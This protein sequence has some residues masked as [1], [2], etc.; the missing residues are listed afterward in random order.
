M[1][2]S[3]TEGEDQDGSSWSTPSSPPIG[4]LEPQPQRDVKAPSEPLSHDHQPNLSH[5]ETPHKQLSTHTKPEVPQH[6]QPSLSIPLDP[7]NPPSTDTFPQKEPEISP[8]LTHTPIPS[9]SSSALV[10]DKS[11]H[12]A[13][14]NFIHHLIKPLALHYPHQTLL[15]LREILTR[16]L[17]ERYSPTWDEAHPDFGSGFRSLICDGEHG[18]PPQLR[19]AA[20]ECGVEEKVWKKALALR[21]KKGK[22]EEEL[23]KEDWEAWCDPGY[24]VWRY[25]GWEWEDSGYEPFRV[26]KEP[27]HVIWQAMPA[28]ASVSVTPSQAPIVQTSRP[29]YAIPIRAPETQTPTPVNAE[30]SG[31][32]SRPSSSEGT[33]SPSPSPRGDVYTSTSNSEIDTTTGQ[34]ERTGRSPR[35]FGGRGSTSS[36]TSSEANSSAQTLL[37]PSS[38]PSSVEPYRYLPAVQVGLKDKNQPFTPLPPSFSHENG[39]PSPS[40]LNPNNGENQQTIDTTDDLTP[41]ANLHITPLSSHNP[42]TNSTGG[43]G[44]ATTPIITPYDGGNVTVLGG[45]VKLGGSTPRFPSGGSYDRSRS[46][47]IS[48]ASRTLH[49]ALSPTGP[50]SPGPGRRQRRRR[51]MPTFLGHLGQPG[52]GG[53]VLG[54]GMTM[55]PPNLNQSVMGRMNMP[56]GMGNR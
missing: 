19:E 18:L 49:T 51:I 32:A 20:K 55:S 47:S 22:G 6:H 36:S 45:G 16:I 44:S 27:F 23:G 9:I 10:L 38:R 35:S 21:L 5:Q 11:L 54:M 25:G 28:E 17:A 43:N 50:G 56:S 34:T 41:T 53:P 31:N 33:R 52:I 13:L 14:S 7:F 1:A 40:P 15:S 24:V 26:I 39:S 12:T 30:R 29:N 42:N 3:S 48:L 37:T 4:P 46:P 8:A 2:S